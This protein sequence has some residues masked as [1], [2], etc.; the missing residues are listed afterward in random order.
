MTS[1]TLITGFFHK[2]FKGMA[3]YK[4]IHWSD[5]LKLFIQVHFLSQNTWYFYSLFFIGTRNT[6]YQEKCLRKAEK[7]PAKIWS[8]QIVTQGS[9]EDKGE[10]NLL[11]RATSSYP[12]HQ[13]KTTTALKEQLLLPSASAAQGPRGSFFPAT[14]LL[15]QKPLIPY[16]N[17]YLML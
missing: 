12:Q 5:P 9:S 6:L 1:T 7:R 15:F 4:S 14:A 13:T 8:H 17:I 3:L 2:T 10:H 16:S 11:H